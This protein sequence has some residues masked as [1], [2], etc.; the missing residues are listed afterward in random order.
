MSHRKIGPHSGKGFD[1]CT[2]FASGV[3][4]QPPGAGRGM[5]KRRSRMRK[6]ALLA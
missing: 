6:T 3:K 4:D 5:V 1:I 2:T